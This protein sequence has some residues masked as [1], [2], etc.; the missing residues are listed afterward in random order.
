[1][2]VPSA[3]N[4]GLLLLLLLVAAA[5]RAG[6]LCRQC[7]VVAA[8]AAGCCCFLC[9]CWFLWVAAAAAGCCCW[10]GHRRSG[11]TGTNSV[12]QVNGCGRESSGG[13]CQTLVCN[14]LIIR[15][16][17]SLA[18]LPFWR[19][20]SRFESRLEFNHIFNNIALNEIESKRLRQHWQWRILHGVDAPPKPIIRDYPKIIRIIPN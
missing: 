4:A 10:T 5:A 11:P 7:W 12:P 18:V 19:F 6:S 1:M 17:G 9:W 2:L 13:T 15:A 16:S 14:S 20:L 8:A 3:G